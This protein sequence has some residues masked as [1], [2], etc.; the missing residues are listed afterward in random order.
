MQSVVLAGFM[1][2]G[3]T[4]VGQALAALTG[5]RFVDLDE[6][7]ASSAGM[8]VEAIFASEGEGGFRARETAAIERLVRSLEA[9]AGGLVGHQKPAD[10]L[11]ALGLQAAGIQAAV[12]QGSGLRRSSEGDPIVLATGGGAVV[13]AENRA[14]LHR[15]GPV[16]ILRARTATLWKRVSGSDRPLA[17]DK[18]AFEA[19]LAARRRIYDAFPYQVDTAGLDAASV[20]Q[21]IAGRFLANGVTVDVALGD[22]SYPIMVEPGGL[23]RLGPAMAGCLR[24]ARCLVVS[25]PSIWK[26]YGPLVLA[27]LESAGWKPGV[28]LI[29]PGEG[30]KSLARMQGLYMAMV[31]HRMDRRSPVVAVGGGVVGDLTGFAAASYLRGVPFVQVP[32]TLLAQVDSSVGGKVGVNLPEGKNLVG[33]FHQPE[34]VLADP[35]SL[36]TLPKRE[37]ASGLAELIKYGVILDSELFERLERDIDAVLERRPSVLVPLVARACELKAQVVAAD[38]REGGLRRI[39]NYGHTLGH[40]IES[41]SGYGRILHGEAVAIGMV[42]AARIGHQMGLCDDTVADRLEALL[43]RAGLPVITDL[44]SDALIEAMAVDKKQTADGLAWILPE[45]IGAVVFRSDVPKAL[46]GDYPAKL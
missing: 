14:F 29:P 24:P 35:L 42:S 2:T 38:E 45:R 39:L 5:A 23:S 11:Q 41:V 37:F 21:A 8:S 28:H 46:I 19:L 10:G 3:K 7:I 13:S 26:L 27:S 12:F 31:A 33:A 16:L 40:A 22:R 34:L 36:Q 17:K 43:R 6:A 9:A 44:S 25:H 32:T 15:I 1:G 18:G 20:A 4:V 30:T